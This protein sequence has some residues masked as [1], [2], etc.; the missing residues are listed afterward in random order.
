MMNEKVNKAFNEQ[1]NREFYSA[2]LYLGMSEWLSRNAWTNSASW[3]VEQYREEI[4]HAEGLMRW[5]Q[6]CDGEV[7]FYAIGAVHTNYD[8]LLDVFEKALAHE[9]F[10]TKSIHGL[11]KLTQENEDRASE[12][13]LDWYVMEQV[14]EEEVARENI[15][16]IKLAG[17]DRKALIDFDKS[18]VGRTFT[19]P[20]IPYLE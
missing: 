2:Y 7:E 15:D 16:N 8:S 3:M 6:R 5:I 11:V 18:M 13:F 19:P 4:A 12:L 10:V 17:D 20:A 14:E 9:Q 1:M